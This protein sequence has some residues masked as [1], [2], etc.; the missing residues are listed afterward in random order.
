MSDIKNGG[1]AFPWVDTLR[2]ETHQG[3][4]LLDWFAGQA[5][6]GV[7]SD[8]NLNMEQEQIAAGSYSMAQAMLE[9]R[10]RYIK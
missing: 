6:A 5:L 3:M 2:L 1:P 8:P 10:K 9:K 4:T 7:M